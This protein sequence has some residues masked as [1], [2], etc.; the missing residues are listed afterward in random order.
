MLLTKRGEKNSQSP[1][2]QHDIRPDQKLCRRCNSVISL[3]LQ[4]CPFCGNAPWRWHQN[5]RFLI[6][7]LLICIF[8]FILFPLITNHEKT[9]RVP[10]TDSPDETAP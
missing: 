9:Y 6:V 3:E 10:V 7:T 2:D 4:R 8:V 5:A 1:T